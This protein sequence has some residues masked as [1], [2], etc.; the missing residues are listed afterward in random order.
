MKRL[1][2][3]RN[4]CTRDVAD[5]RTLATDGEQGLRCPCCGALCK[6]KIID[7]AE[8]LERELAAMK[9]TAEDYRIQACRPDECRAKTELAAFVRLLDPVDGNVVSAMVR[10]R[11]LLAVKAVKKP[12]AGR[13]TCCFECRHNTGSVRKCGKDRSYCH[14]NPATCDGISKCDGISDKT[15]GICDKFETKTPKGQP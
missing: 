15:C 1:L 7:K 9:A 11:E 5:T 12:I 2:W 4:G 13:D 14:S 6:I 10:L 8:K 3:W